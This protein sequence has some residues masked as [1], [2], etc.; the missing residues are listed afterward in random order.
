MSA[1]QSGGGGLAYGS[2]EFVGLPAALTLGG[3]RSVV[4]TA[5]TVDDVLPAL[6]AMNVIPVPWVEPDDISDAVLFL[7]SEEASGIT[8]ATLAVAA[9]AS[10]RNI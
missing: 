7:A 1:C 2:D 9:G 4:C 5:W 10:A 3:V 8:G 6:A